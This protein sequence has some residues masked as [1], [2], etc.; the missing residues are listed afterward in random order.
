MAATLPSVVC[1]H[2]RFQFADVRQIVAGRWTGNS[3]ASDASLPRRR[4]S[5]RRFPPSWFCSGRFPAVCSFSVRCCS[6]R[7]AYCNPLLPVSEFLDIFRNVVSLALIGSGAGWRS[8]CSS[9]NRR[10]FLWRV[11]RK[12]ILSYIF[13]GLVPAV[14]IV[15]FALAGGAVLYNNVAAYLFHESFDDL[16]EDVHQIAETAALEI[17]RARRTS[18]QA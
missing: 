2:S 18:R 4:A 11:R 14:L 5:R 8:C 17:G 7:S 9:R 13:L 12:L 1:Y 3:P 6:S 16:V 15:A 10:T